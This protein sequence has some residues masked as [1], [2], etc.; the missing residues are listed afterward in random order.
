MRSSGHF[1]QDFRQNI[2]FSETLGG[3]A[4]IRSS[5][6]FPQ[7]FRQNI[8]SPETLGGKAKIRPFEHFPQDFREEA[9][10]VI[11]KIPTIYFL[12]NVLILGHPGESKIILIKELR[13]CPGYIRICGNVRGAS[14]NAIFETFSTGFQTENQIFGNIRGESESTTFET[15]STGFQTEH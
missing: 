10:L 11:P 6:H 7:D 3:K 12:K 1:P 4:E 2:E 13:K 9:E 8:E 5:K 15:F 14:E